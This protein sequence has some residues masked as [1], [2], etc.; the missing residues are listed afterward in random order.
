MSDI[1]LDL[2]KASPTFNDY[3]LIDGDLALTSD[4]QQGGADPVQQDIL[5][6]MRTFLNEWYLDNTL[7]IPWFQQILIKNPDQ[8]KIDAI[9]IN[10]ILS[11][12]GV[13]QLLSYDFE[14][15]RPDRILKDTFKV[16]RTTGKV[17]YSGTTGGT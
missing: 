10:T 5:Q 9:F 8:S 14:E 6:A 4:V 3:L 16:Q 11:R 1:S 12:R 7:G 17:D 13:I 15:I 2:D